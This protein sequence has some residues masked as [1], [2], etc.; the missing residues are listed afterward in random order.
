MQYTSLATAEI[1][2]KD[3]G[4][5]RGLGNRTP[6]VQAESACGCGS[7]LLQRARHSREHT[8]HEANRQGVDALPEHSSQHGP[9]STVELR[10]LRRLA[11]AAD[12]CRRHASRC[13][14]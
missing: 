5:T 11:Q 3:Q 14:P 7:A 2:W 10:R 8:S 13:R 4:S 6:I 12:V 1:L 9:T